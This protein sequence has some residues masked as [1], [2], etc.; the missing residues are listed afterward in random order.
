MAECS[1]HYVEQTWDSYYNFLDVWVNLTDLYR[2]L[3]DIAPEDAFASD[4][5]G[6]DITAQ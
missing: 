1:I 3:D 6:R 4:L 5:Q 2:G